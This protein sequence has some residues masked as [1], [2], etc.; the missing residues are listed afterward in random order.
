MSGQVVDI[1]TLDAVKT[2]TFS[3]DTSQYASGDLI[4]NTQELPLAMARTGMP[5]TL[6]SV[7]LTDGAD[8]KA[9][10]TLV[11]LSDSTSLGT[12]NVAPNISDANVRD[13]VLGSVSVPAANYVDLGGAS[14]ATVTG[15][16]L[17]L[18]GAATTKSLYVG[19]VNGTGTPTYGAADLTVKFG[20]YRNET[21]T[22]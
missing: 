10:V 7:V 16:G 15:I 17:L 19:I 12:E 2:L 3:T 9:A 5:V 14:V 18:Q 4:A 11:F 13:K 22:G 6:M 21:Y 1:S 8:Q 20:F